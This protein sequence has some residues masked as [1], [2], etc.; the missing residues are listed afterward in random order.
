[1]TNKREAYELFGKE[2][3][4]GFQG[5]LGT[6]VQTFDSQYLYPT[7]EEQ[8]AN[9]LYLIIKNHPF[10]DGNKRIGSFMFVWFLEKNKHQLN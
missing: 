8:A 4:D 1:M 3:S 10:S 7:V 6:I 5:V 9:L 2:R